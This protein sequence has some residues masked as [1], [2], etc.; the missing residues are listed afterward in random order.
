MSLQPFLIALQFLTIIPVQLAEPVSPK[1][2]G[3]SL[4]Y[5]PLI[6]LIISLPLIVF[7][8]F[9][10]SYPTTVAA[11]IVLSV[12]VLLS[13]GLHL[14]GL[15][16][17]A[18]AWLGGLGDQDKTL[19]IMKDPAS[20][21]IAVVTLV[22]LLLI[23]FVMLTVLIEQQALW[24]IM[25]SIVLARTVMPLLFLTTP[26]IRHNGLGA[27]LKQHQPVTETRYLLLS[28]ALLCFLTAGPIVLLIFISIFVFLRY[29]M[30]QRLGGFTGDTAGAMVEITEAG[31]LIFFALL[32]GSV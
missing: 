12:W 26:Y 7:S 20:G 14:D 4:L 9:L 32:L 10:G 15:A 17:S 8:T 27:L 25:W 11:V 21:P 24:P 1:H 23:K 29:L 30:E 31:L 3:N 19:K 13:G 18:D 6:G 2:L 16:D 22:L 5:Y 28:I